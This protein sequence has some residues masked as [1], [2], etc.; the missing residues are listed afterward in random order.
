MLFLSYAG[1]AFTGFALIIL[2]VIWIV[3]GYLNIPGFPTGVYI[4]QA[5][6][7]VF[8]I[9]VAVVFGKRD[10]TNIHWTNY[11]GKSYVSIGSHYG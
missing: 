10:V 2:A 8:V 7:L 5:I 1:P 11:C 9:I 6:F 3:L 4:A